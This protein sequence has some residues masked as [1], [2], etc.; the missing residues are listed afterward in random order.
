MAKYVAELLYRIDPL[1]LK[2]TLIIKVLFYNK[3]GKGNIFYIA[4]SLSILFYFPLISFTN[5]SSKVAFIFEVIVGTGTP[6]QSVL[7]KHFLK[8]SFP[9]NL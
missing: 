3:L 7:C 4:F 2:Q 9:I 8:F 5:E 6:T 1:L